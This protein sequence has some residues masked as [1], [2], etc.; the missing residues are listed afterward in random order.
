MYNLKYLLFLSRLEKI[1][2]SFVLILGLIPIIPFMGPMIFSVPISLSIGTLSILL[3]LSIFLVFKFKDHSS[4]FT[5]L[6]IFFY[7]LIIFSIL[8][9]VFKWFSGIG[10]NDRG[11][12]VYLLAFITLFIIVSLII[13]YVVKRN[14]K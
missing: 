11:S 3:F 4:A 13:T 2:G 7:V 5:W 12:S 10:I 9:T 6:R 1:L 8:S 14:K